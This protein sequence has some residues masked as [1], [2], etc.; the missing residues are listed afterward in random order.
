MNRNSIP[1]QRQSTHQGP[2]LWLAVL[3]PT[4]WAIHFLACYV[5]AAVWCE[6]LGRAAP[7]AGITPAI[8]A[9]TLVALMAQLWLGLN[10]WR[11]SATSHGARQ[12]F[13][14]KLTLSL[15]GLSAIAVIFVTWPLLA[16]EL[17]R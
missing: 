10:L 12:K 17:C 5:V 1:P 14:T 6:K 9:L 11:K 4:I 3:G 15:L 16:L 7:L 13:M 8:V 2:N